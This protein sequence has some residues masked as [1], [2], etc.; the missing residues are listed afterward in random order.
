MKA[1]DP[2][3]AELDAWA[4]AGRLATLWWRDD[5]AAWP[6]DAVRR[7]LALS[8]DTGVPVFLAVVPAKAVD[9]LGPAI[10][11]CP[12]AVP[13]QHG[14]AHQDHAP[15]DVKG[16]WELGLHRP[17]DAILDELR[18]GRLR[19][20]ELFG[21]RLEAMLCPP[22]NRIAPEVAAALPGL[23]LT[24]L[25]TFAPRPSATPAPGLLQVNGH[26]DIIAWKRGRVFIGAEKTALRLAEH[27]AERRAGSVDADEP[28]GLLT[29]AW[30]HDEDAW[31]TLAAVLRLVARHSAAQWQGPREIM[32]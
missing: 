31:T 22:W 1:L 21:D 19:L 20:A 17:L 10:A 30:A 26:C 29:H 9:A 23:G 16:K 4:A 2:L 3:R 28:T 12:A 32:A 25:S 18:R 13:V 7:L 6:S 11:A 14:F 5:D 27:L 24:H 15:A 8:A